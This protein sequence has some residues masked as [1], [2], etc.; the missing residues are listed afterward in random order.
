MI[1]EHLGEKITWLFRTSGERYDAAASG[2][3]TERA[4]VFAAKVCEGLGGAD[5][6]IEAQTLKVTAARAAMMI[7]A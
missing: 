4:W 2:G 5:G 3:A 7:P 1:F 6:L